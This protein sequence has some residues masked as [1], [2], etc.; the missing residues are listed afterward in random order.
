MWLQQ[1]ILPKIVRA[2]GGFT[3]EATERIMIGQIQV[4]G[5]EDFDQAK[6]VEQEKK[7][8]FRLQMMH[9]KLS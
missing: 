4:V 8:W 9:I 6:A 3:T 2:A 7:C 1:D 5:C